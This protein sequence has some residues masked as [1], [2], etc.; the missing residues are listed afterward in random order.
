MDTKGYE[1]GQAFVRK[2]GTFGI[3]AFLIIFIGYFIVTFFFGSRTVLDDYRPPQ[4][5]EYYASHIDELAAE[6]ESDI[7][8]LLE[9]IDECFVEDGRVIVVTDSGRFASVRTAL[10]KVFDET[11]VDVRIGGTQ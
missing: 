7:S 11:L 2:I 6:I 3:V 10:L 9:G 1:T 5:N 8:P 4:T